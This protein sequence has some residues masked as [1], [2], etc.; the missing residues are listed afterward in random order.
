M[1]RILSLLLSVLLLFALSAC[2]AAPQGESET[3]EA[4]QL[5]ELTLLPSAAE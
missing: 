4:S 2:A 3:P 5:P 1:K